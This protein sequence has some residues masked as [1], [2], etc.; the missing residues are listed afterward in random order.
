MFWLSL[1]RYTTEDWKL[2]RQPLYCEATMSNNLPT[3]LLLFFM[4][5]SLLLLCFVGYCSKKILV[6]G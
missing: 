4:D 5:Y 3:I 6:T 1:A 2:K